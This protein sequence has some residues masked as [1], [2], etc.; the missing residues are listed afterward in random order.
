MQAAKIIL[1][2]LLV[3]PLQSGCVI[4]ARRFR[5]SRLAAVA[6][7]GGPASCPCCPP[8]ALTTG[9]ASRCPSRPPAA[10]MAGVLP[11]ETLRATHV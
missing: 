8:S 2:I 10:T 6:A 9:P 4:L 1:A 3:R 5:G 11:E 7:G